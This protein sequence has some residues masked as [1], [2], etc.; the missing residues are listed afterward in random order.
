MEINKNLAPFR[1]FIKQN[2]KYAVIYANSVSKYA[3]G[4]NFREEAFK[5][6]SDL[7]HDIEKDE[8]LYI[9]VNLARVITRIFRDYVIGLGYNV[10][11]AKGDEINKAFVETSDE[12]ELQVK[13]D[14]AVN[15]Q[16]SI[17]YG[18]LRLRAV[19]DGSGKATPRVEVIPLP[20]YCANME[21]L[22]IGD[23]FRDIKEHYIFSVQKDANDRTY[24]YVDRYEK[25]DNGQWKGYYGERWANN[26]S[27]ILNDR[28][29]EAESEEILDDLPLFILNNDLDNPHVVSDEED[30]A[31]KMV[32]GKSSVG[33]IPRFFHQSDYVDIADILQEINDRGSQIS[34]EFIKNLTSKMSVPAGFRD[35]QTMQALKNGKD[36]KFSKNPDYLVHNPGEEPARYITKD[37]EYVK[38]SINEYLPYLLKLL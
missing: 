8:V 29:Q 24:F 11:F 12:I 27:F 35:A 21:G 20:N 4:K 7:A 18:I 36:P 1:E 3:T 22:N 16:S 32:N 37:A 28:I 25:L 5:V 13:L 2:H 34:V 19:T 6:K 26:G 9:P 15:N 14:E 31:V 23:D 17:G 33:N 38:T 10:D 30:G